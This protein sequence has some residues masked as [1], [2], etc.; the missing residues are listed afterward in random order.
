MDLSFKVSDLRRL[1]ILLSI[2]QYVFLATK[3]FIG[4]EGTKPYETI[5]CFMPRYNLTSLKV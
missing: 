2:I 3:I 1:S 4:I 5:F